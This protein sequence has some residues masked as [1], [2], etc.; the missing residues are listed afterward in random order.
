MT[1]LHSNIEHILKTHKGTNGLSLYEHL[2]AI[3]TRLL[4]EPNKKDVI[5]N[6]EKISH[7]LKHTNF[8]YKNPLP[9]SIVNNL[10]EPRGE[11]TEWI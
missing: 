1:E 8:K 10:E 4:K 9:D 11:L 2:L 5:T 7:F 3:F 6:F